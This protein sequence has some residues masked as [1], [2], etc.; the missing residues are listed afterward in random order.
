MSCNVV[1]QRHANKHKVKES[2]LSSCHANFDGA[3]RDSFGNEHEMIREDDTVSSIKSNLLWFEKVIRIIKMHFLLPSLR[4]SLISFGIRIMSNENSWI[5]KIFICE[6]NWNF[7]ASPWEIEDMTFKELPWVSKI[8]SHV[9]FL[10]NFT[11]FAIIEVFAW[12]PSS[13]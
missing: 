5:R 10:V 3:F 6:L 2:C 12:C 7:S 4:R 9:K 13:C 1:F 8:F 11:R